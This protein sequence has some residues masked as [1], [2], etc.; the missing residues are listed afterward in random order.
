MKNYV[1]QKNSLMTFSLKE[2]APTFSYIF[3]T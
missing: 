3:M 1:N 2:I